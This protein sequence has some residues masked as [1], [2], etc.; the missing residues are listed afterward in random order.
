LSSSHNHAVL[1]VLA[2]A[3]A[4]GVVPLVDW[5][6]NYQGTR[7]DIPEGLDQLNL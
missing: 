5:H 2:R 4:S 1:E 7:H 3:A 6:T